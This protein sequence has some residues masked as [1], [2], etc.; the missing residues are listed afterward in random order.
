MYTD[1]NTIGLLLVGVLFLG[2]G[3]FIFWRYRVS[4]LFDFTNEQI[5]EVKIQAKKEVELA[6]ELADKRIEE[7]KASVER[8]YV[9]QRLFIK[10]EQRRLRQG[11]MELESGKDELQSRSRDIERNEVELKRRKEGVDELRHFY[12]QRIQDIAG[13]KE[14]DA[15]LLLKEETFRD[16]QQ[17]IYAMRREL[18]EKSALEL[19]SEARRILVD[20]LGRLTMTPSSSLSAAVVKL[21]N[22]EIKGRLIGKEGRNIRSFESATGTNLVIDESPGTVL[23]SSFDPIRREVAYLSLLRLIDDGRIHPLS[24]EETVLEVEREMERK[25]VEYG[26]R[27]LHDLNIVGVTQDVVILLGKLH[28]RLSN[29][30][31]TLEHS[32][33]VAKLCSMMAAELGLDVEIAKRCGLYHDLG[34]GIEDEFEKSH[35]LAAA[36]ILKRH[37]EDPRVVNAVAASHGEEAA[38]SVY[39]E[40]L[41]IADRL[42]ATLPGARSSSLE[43]YISRVRSLEALASSFEGVEDAYA[44]Q[45]GK[46]LRVIISPE[47][48]AD[49]DA[50]ILT[51]NIRRRVESEL[52]YSGKIKV[53]V[54]REQRF[55]ALAR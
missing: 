42:S 53:T 1:W 9:D 12:Q 47:T 33:E 32:I 46:E 20:S 13:M 50:A 18:L 7:E 39:A 54:I 4:R 21:P 14:E 15:I 48:Y 8:H 26:E 29:N 49:G 30:Q 44:L 27:A 11:F 24:I 17:E 52:N 19:E 34:K 36:G 31:N 41:K 6:Q 22:D 38:E 40:L 37:F 45:S 35:A 25:I 23:V 28:F 10:S 5:L 43:G 3:F 55:T 16:C 2:V 51:T